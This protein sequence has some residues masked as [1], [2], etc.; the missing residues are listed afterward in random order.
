M[1]N[2]ERIEITAGGARYDEWEKVSVIAAIDEAVRQ[3]SIETTERSGSFR[4]PP[5]TPVTITANGELVVDGFTNAYEA[6]ADAKTHRISIRGRSKGQDFVDSS[7]DHSTGQFQNRKPD[8]IATEL[9]KWPIAIVADVPLEPIENAQLMPGES[10]FQMIE[11][12]LRPEG[13]SM[14]GAP[15]GDIHL[16]NASVAQSHYGILMEGHTIK[17][18]QIS[19][20][21]GSRHSRYIVKGQRR[22]GTGAA[23]LRI[24]RE[25]KDPA[26]KRDRPKVLAN[27]TDTDDRRATSRAEHERERAAGNSVQASVQ[28]QGWRDF[29]GKIFS[30]NH[31][32]YVHAPTLMHMSETMLIKSVELTQDKSGSLTSLHLVDPRAFKGRGSGGNVPGRPKKAETDPAWNEGWGYL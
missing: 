10:P 11:R 3:F 29:A 4:F 21:D 26:V 7:A 27:E 6:S 30:P 1:L 17:S 22:K 28:T 18:F 12:Y 13:V 23:A 24:K 25:A 5:G 15:N 32:I 16:T 19:L 9:N 20:T 8:D 2:V 14:M 31:L